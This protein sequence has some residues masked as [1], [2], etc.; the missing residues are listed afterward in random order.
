MGKRE[1]RDFKRARQLGLT[2]K[3]ENKNKKDLSLLFN[4]FLF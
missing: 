4:C 2:K 1:I 3:N